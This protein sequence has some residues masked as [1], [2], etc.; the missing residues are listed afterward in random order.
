MSVVVCVVVSWPLGWDWLY[1]LAILAGALLA[2]VA[3]HGD[4]LC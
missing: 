2:A 3:R 4:Y 1:S